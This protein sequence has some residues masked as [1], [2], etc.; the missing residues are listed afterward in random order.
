MAR[1]APPKVY[2]VSK[3]KPGDVTIDGEDKD[4]PEERIDD[5]RNGDFALAYD[6]AN[7]YVLFNGRDNRAVF[8]NGATNFPDIFKH[9]D[10]VDIKLQTNAGLKPSRSRA[11]RGDIRLSFAMFEDNPTCVLYDFDVE[12]IGKGMP[13]SSPWRTEWIDK[14]AIIPEAKIQVNR[15]RDRYCLEAAVPLKVIHLDPKALGRTR[16]DVG[17]VLSDQTGSTGAARVYWANKNTHIV[18]DLPSEAALQPSLWGMFV[19]ERE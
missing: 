12:G 9:G 1:Q 7:L 8:K 15:E 18:S 6:D 17:R 16:G 2:A 14:V 4:W 11:G 3:V 13:F 19:F 10:V 5:G